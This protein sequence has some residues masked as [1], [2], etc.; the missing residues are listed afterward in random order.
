TDSGAGAVEVSNFVRPTMPKNG[1][2]TNS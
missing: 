2:P 1:I